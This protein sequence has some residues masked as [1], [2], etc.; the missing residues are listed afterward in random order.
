MT[1]DIK[2]IYSEE[3][4]ASLIPTTVQLRINRHTTMT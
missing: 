4:A 2:V 3:T 1:L